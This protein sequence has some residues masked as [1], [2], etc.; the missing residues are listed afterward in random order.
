MQ[1]ANIEKEKVFVLFMPH[2]VD[3]HKTLFQRLFVWFLNHF[4]PNFS[5]VAIFK[6]SRITG[7]YIEINCCSDNFKVEEWT[8]ENF[9]N[10]LT[11]P[12]ITSKLVEVKPGIVKAKGL[13]TCVSIA[14]HYLGICDKPLII[15]P[16][17]LFKYLE[18]TYGK[19]EK[20]KSS[21]GANTGLHSH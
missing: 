11:N 17:Q 20:G 12:K 16:Y 10:L 14:K 19:Q 18:K 8:I 4:K 15:T 21:S 5:H 9:F 13:I 2:S 7:G 6:K 1:K 3:D